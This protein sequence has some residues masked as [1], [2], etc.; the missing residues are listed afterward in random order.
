MRI[1]ILGGV[2]LAVTVAVL[3][4]RRGTS[5]L[6]AR[7]RQSAPATER[8]EDEGGALRGRSA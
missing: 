6:R 4:A 7:P 5:R 2:M 1:L 8:W 3:K